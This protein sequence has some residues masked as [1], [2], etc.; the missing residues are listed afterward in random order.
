MTTPVLS[1]HARGQLGGTVGKLAIGIAI[2]V[3]SIFVLFAFTSSEPLTALQGL[4][5]G[6]LSSP[7]RLA[8]WLTYSS[9]L[10]LTGASVCLAFR[11]GMFSIGAEGQVFVGALLAGFVALTMGSSPFTL[12]IAILLSIVGGFV[13]GMI[14]GLMK[15][16]LGADEIV[17][18]LMMNYIATFL[19]A[20]II[21]EFLKPADAGFPV[22][23][24]FAPQSWFPAIGSPGIST[25]L[26]L[27]I[28]VCGVVSVLLNRTRLG[29]AFRMVGDSPRF[30]HANGLNVP[31]LIW[32]SI[33][34]SGA[35]AGL[36]GAAIAFGST[37]RLILGMATGIGFDGILVA[38]LAINRPILV[39]LTALAYGYLRT[40]GDVIQITSNVPRD[41]VVILQGAVILVLA[42]LL[43]QRERKLRAQAALVDD[44]TVTGGIDVAELA[45]L[46]RA[47]APGPDPAIVRTTGHDVTRHPEPDA[48]VLPEHPS[49]RSS[50]V[51][52]KR[53]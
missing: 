48:S 40:G 4:F 9:F 31:R 20:Y 37:H 42:A 3:V 26:V 16:Y 2:A 27:G 39:P 12:P 8:Q 33:A 30:A 10:M 15:A 21:K 38:L 41:I 29:Y 22:S 7:G 14:P 53:S 13:W 18:T 44:F 24:F 25:T 47:S 5:T 49:E 28:I 52:G 11:V 17:T 50:D 34:L 46:E 19:F 23:E 32:L 1:R 51:L 6:A 36:A 45:E 43:K 35:V